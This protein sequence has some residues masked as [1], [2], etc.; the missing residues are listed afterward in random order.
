MEVTVAAIF[1]MGE[2]A[3]MVTLAGFPAS[4]YSQ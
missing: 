3:V 1:K 2:I 4:L